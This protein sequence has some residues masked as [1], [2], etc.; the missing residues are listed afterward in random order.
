MRTAMSTNGKTYVPRLAQPG[1]PGTDPLANAFPHID[2]VWEKKPRSRRC[3]C[4][5]AS[6]RI[7]M[8]LAAIRISCSD[9]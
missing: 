3:D 7:Y 8:S 5:N 4:S 9:C 1:P 2:P 6:R